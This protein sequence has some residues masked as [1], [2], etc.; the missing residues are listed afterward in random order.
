[1]DLRRKAT[2]SLRSMGAACLLA[3]AATLASAAPTYGVYATELVSLSLSP[4]FFGG[5]VDR[6]PSW[7]LPGGIQQQGTLGLPTYIKTSTAQSASNGLVT[8]SGAYSASGYIDGP[9]LHGSVAADATNTITCLV[10]SG[11]SSSRVSANIY[12]LWVDTISVSAPT[13]VSSVQVKVTA[14]FDGN[15]GTDASY[16]LDGSGKPAQPTNAYFQYDFLGTG[17]ADTLRGSFNHLANGPLTFDDRASQVLT[18]IPGRAISVELQL[19]L[20]A[21]AGTSAGPSMASIGAMNTGAFDIEFLTPGATLTSASGFS[22]APVV[23][24]SIPEPATPVLMLAG[25]VCLF[26]KTRRNRIGTVFEE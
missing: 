15:G 21:Y 12:E 6:P 8:V 22:Y 18:L 11:C 3:T 4:G 19:I 25:L 10:A 24:S 17:G 14:H 13:G 2:S 9:A 1:M 5:V 20:S 23:V 7:T 26:A 16:L